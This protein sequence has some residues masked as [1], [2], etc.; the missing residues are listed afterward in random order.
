MYVIEETGTGLFWSNAN[1]FGDRKSADIF[2]AKER[3]TFHLPVGGKWCHETMTD[4]NPLFRCE[5]TRDESWKAYDARGIYLCRVC[6][7]CEAHK[8][9]GY[10]P[11]VLTD[12]NYW[13][14]EPIDYDY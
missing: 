2:S 12:F 3:L 11:D 14:D 8:M 1:G 10:R 13:S 9:R 5:H 6:E 4:Y 7:R